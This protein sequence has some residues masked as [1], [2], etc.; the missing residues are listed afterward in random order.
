MKSFNIYGDLLDLKDIEF[1]NGR[2][3][4]IGYFDEHVSHFVERI[5]L[6][7]DGIMADV[8]FI[9]GEHL[10]SL[11]ERYYELGLGQFIIDY[12]FNERMGMVINFMVLDPKV[13][14]REKRL[15]NLGI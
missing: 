2:R 6:T 14:L 1:Y 7:K 8:K 4:R 5:Y 10:R 13:V 3:D 9:C 11:I 12:V 15:L